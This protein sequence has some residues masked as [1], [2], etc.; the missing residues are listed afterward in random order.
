M[1]SPD[2]RP[3]ICTPEHCYDDPHEDDQQFCVACHY[4]PTNLCLAREDPIRTRIRFVSSPVNRPPCPHT[5]LR[6]RTLRAA[7]EGRLTRARTGMAWLSINASFSTPSQISRAAN[8][9]LVSRL[10]R[11]DVPLGGSALGCPLIP[12]D[13]GDALLDRWDERYGRP[14]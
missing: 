14:E 12:T 8:A 10:V 4:D 13:E 6:H 11:F 9:L 5:P 2:R 7:R 1:T 3:C